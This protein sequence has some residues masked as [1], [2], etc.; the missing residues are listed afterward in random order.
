MQRE[1]SRTRAQAGL[2]QISSILGAQLESTPFTGKY[3]M[4]GKLFAAYDFYLV[5]PVSPR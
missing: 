3:S 4:F 5:R 1:P 2:Q